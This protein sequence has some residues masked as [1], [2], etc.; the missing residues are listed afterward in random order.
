[1]E[2]P[3]L[4]YEEK[5]AIVEQNFQDLLKCSPRLAS[6]QA[7]ELVT[8]AFE[9]ADKGHISQ[10]RKGGQKLPYIT[11]PITVAKIVAQEMGFGK[12]AVVAALLHDTVEDCPE[13]SLQDIETN[14]GKE[15]AKIIDGLTK[16]KTV[17]KNCSKTQQSETF[18][19]MFLKM[20]ESKL[21]AFIKIADRLHNM[22]TLADMS[23]SSKMIKTAESLM[24]YA[25]I[26]HRLGLFVIKKELENLSFEYRHPEEFKKVKQLVDEQGKRQANYF[27]QIEKVLK[28][29][30][31][32]FQP[33]FQVKK[34]T[35]S[36]Y[37]V[38]GK[39]KGNHKEVTEIHNFNSLRIIFDPTD[40][41]TEKQQCF[42]FY[43]LLTDYF[44]VN[45]RGTKDWVTHPKTNGFETLLVNLMI[46]GQW[47]EVQI[48]T[49]RMNQIAMRG[50]AE[51]H[52]NSRQ[53]LKT[54]EWLKSLSQQLKDPNLTHEQVLRII[55]PA[56]KEIHVFTDR[57]EL[58][59]MK[60]GSTV[61][62]YAFHI[63]TELGLKFRAAEV[64]GTPAPYSTVLTHADSVYIITCESCQ[65]S[66]KWLDHITTSKAES[67]LQKYFRGLR[68][69]NI[70]KGKIIFNF[71]IQEY[72]V[73]DELFKTLCQRFAC[74]S[75]DEIYLRLANNSI[76]HEELKKE[77]LPSRPFSFW[78]L[79]NTKE[80]EV[81]T[82]SKKTKETVEDRI[83]NFNPKKPFKITDPEG[84]EIS[85][86]CRPVPGDESIVIK[87]SETRLEVH[88]RDCQTAH[89]KNAL[90]KEQT[91][92]VIWKL[93]NNAVFPAEVEF[94][95]LDRTHI[96][97][98][99]VKVISNEMGINMIALNV[100]A[101]KEVFK[102]SIEM[103]VA[104]QEVINHLVGDLKKIQDLEKVYR[105]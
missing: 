84:I 70:K 41:H 78:G 98:D 3:H 2:L 42:M 19:D 22:R 54:T 18:K 93:S 85:T 103:L 33:N 9:F 71:I 11:H 95:G 94:K 96:L 55:K 83:T 62:D 12:T 23:E 26:A 14:F 52:D 35:K 105:L 88:K 97:G 24:V 8:K 53:F 76:L 13:I 21:I 32:D 6:A 31:K 60:K 92:V 75:M 91:T 65:P 102:G 16:I 89:E 87:C 104:S 47:I 63:H 101:D 80:N 28:A 79:F 27:N 74:N 29:N 59:V 30:L 10:F 81:I 61:L 51:N 43:A 39:M 99:I 38:W 50:F 56:S 73:T 64:N 49:T 57:G 48:M 58:I 36:Y 34:I 100:K 37:S 4:T 67:K 69:E 5:R 86:C 15:V 72:K 82:D 1:M 25:P 7:Q 66:K 17:P 90:F 77:L 44:N 68:L 46:E 20:A 45:V 40:T